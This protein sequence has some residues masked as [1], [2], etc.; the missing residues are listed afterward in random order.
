MP[1]SAHYDIVIIGGG[2]GGYVAAIRAAQL[3]LKT[4]LV[5]KRK[6]L[7]G[8]CLNVGCIPSKA[9]LEMSERY[10]YV[11]AHAGDDGI[12]IA[13]AKLDLEAVMTKKAKS[14]ERL[15][16]GVETLVA[17][18]G[19][20]RFVGAGRLLG[21]GRLRVDSEDGK[22]EIAAKSILLATGS[23]PAELKDLPFDGKTVISSDEAIALP[24]VPKRLAVVGGG[25]IG[26]EL[27]AVWARYGSEVTILEFLP[28][29]AAFMDADASSLLKRLFEKQGMTIRAEAKVVGAEK[30]DGAMVLLSEKDDKTVE[31]H[32]DVVLVAVGRKP[33]AEGLG[34][35]EAGVKRDGQGRV[36]VDEKF[37]TSVE[38]VYAIGDLIPG[39]MLA[40][41]AEEEGVA[42]A[43]I[44]AGKPGHVN[45]QAIPN[46]IYTEPE[47][48][49]VGLGE[50]QAK[51]AG[52]EIRVG[53]FPM[54]ANGRAIATGDTDGF[55][56]I[57][58]CAKTD[59]ILGAQVVSKNASEIVAEVVA[60]IEYGGS[61]E[62][63]GR[64]VHAH[65]TLSEALKEAGLAVGKAA[66]HSL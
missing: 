61:A 40:H 51:E 58:A 4:A 43:E 29:I 34:L 2:P 64:T 59:R 52:R 8:T 33:Y 32:A 55:V 47:A 62:D 21:Q 20:D 12:E 41:K 15:V 22:T 36:E 53:K 27:G 24:D 38:G 46:V 13:N 66:V 35:E 25:A 1:D 65:P 6:A 60:H 16:K 39:P 48:A 45:Y 37:R 28:R 5:E 26:L 54:A 14:V 19:V 11:K 31:T 49:C 44:A 18:R 10:A 23:A 9:L 7:G 17:K 63:L 57:V 50:D 56:K 3:G 30:R 42:V